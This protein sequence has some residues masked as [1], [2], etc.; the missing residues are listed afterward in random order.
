MSTRAVARYP[1]R[2][3]ELVR[4]LKGV[5]H[6]SR[7]SVVLVDEPAVAPAG[8]ATTTGNVTTIR[9]ITTAMRNPE[10]RS[11]TERSAEL[12]VSH[13]FRPYGRGQE[14]GEPT[15]SRRHA[16]T[17][18]PRPR[19]HIGHP[20][21]SRPT[22]PP[23]PKD[24]SES[25]PATKRRELGCTTHRA[26]GQCCVDDSTKPWNESLQREPLILPCNGDANRSRESRPGPA[27]SGQISAVDHPYPRPYY[28]LD[29][30]ALDGQDGHASLKPQ[31]H[32]DVS[33]LAVRREE[34][35]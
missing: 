26:S 3:G 35:P 14:L 22:R 29:A 16:G 30:S 19:A 15:K 7:G 25:A 27:A 24:F 6:G 20:P 13:F 18:T 12:D 23:S 17:H 5:I 32:V 8:R 1:T 34:S 33:G 28:S 21:T 9:Q 11:R 2:T 4:C 10:P 31:H